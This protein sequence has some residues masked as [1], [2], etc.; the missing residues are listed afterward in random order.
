MRWTIDEAVELVERT[1]PRSSVTVADG[2]AD[3]L[4]G[5]IEDDTET[6]HASF[7]L[8]LDSSGYD[9]IEI[10]IAEGQKFCGLAIQPAASESPFHTV[11]IQITRRGVN[12]ALWGMVGDYEVCING[13]TVMKRSKSFE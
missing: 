9:V 13:D 8:E 3:Y 2:D 12:G 11:P 10:R 4:V 6:I 1:F 5:T 7:L